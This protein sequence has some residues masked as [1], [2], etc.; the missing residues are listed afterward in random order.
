MLLDEGQCLWARVLQGGSDHALALGTVDRV[1]TMGWKFVNR[2]GE[3]IEVGVLALGVGRALFHLRGQRALLP[4]PLTQP[5]ADVGIVSD[6]LG[7]DVPRSLQSFLG[8]RYTG[9]RI[10]KGLGDG[11]EVGDFGSVGEDGDGQ[12][13]QSLVAGDAGLGAAFG[14]VWLVE[15]LQF[16]LRR[17]TRNAVA[18][19][20]RELAYGL[21]SL[22][23]DDFARLQLAGV[24]IAFLDRADLVLIQRAGDL[25]AIAGDERHRIAA[26]QQLHGA[27]DLWR[28]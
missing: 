18:Q 13:F 15:V 27:R 28:L 19:L 11:V 23:H 7:D 26:L 8:C 22:Q 17:A 25:F 4:Q 3:V 10:D 14:S 6:A 21:D 24:G 16:L 20:S 5:L 2:L 1:S 12:R 9:L